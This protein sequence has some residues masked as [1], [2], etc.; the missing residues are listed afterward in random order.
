MVINIILLASYFYLPRLGKHAPPDQ[1]RSRMPQKPKLVFE[2]HYDGLNITLDKQQTF[3]F[4]EESGFLRGYM[5]VNLITL[6]EYNPQ[7]IIIAV[8][9]AEDA[10][11]L[12]LSQRFIVGGKFAYGYNVEQGDGL[13]RLNFYFN[14]QYFTGLG[15]DDINYT[16]NSAL[17]K[18]IVRLSALHKK[19]ARLTA[20]EEQAVLRKAV[21]YMQKFRLMYVAQD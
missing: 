9:K 8:Y 5:A 21:D 15:Q 2:N 14:P 19:K 17:V 11:R 7:R 4:L 16:L 20:E 18:A 12:H 6:Q 3:R 10:Q 1:E 13:Y